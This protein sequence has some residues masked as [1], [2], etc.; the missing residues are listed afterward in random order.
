MTPL[1][2]TPLPSTPLPSTPLP[3]TPLPSTPLPSTPLP[4]TP[5]PA[6]PLPSTPLPSTPLPMTPLP[7]TPLPATPLP[8][9]PLP[10]TPLPTTPLPATPLPAT[11]LPA[12]P[13]PY[14]HLKIYCLSV[15]ESRSVHLDQRER[16][17]MVVLLTASVD[18]GVSEAAVSLL[19]TESKLTIEQTRVIL[20][21]TPTTFPVSPDWPLPV[22]NQ[23]HTSQKPRPSLFAEAGRL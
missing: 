15:K 10:S 11:P 18:D 20:F 19:A 2:S 14:P 16:V 9:T 13:L 22:H 12:T 1:P 21:S 8:A 5:L 17:S 3:A 4:S 23:H 6:T 7:M